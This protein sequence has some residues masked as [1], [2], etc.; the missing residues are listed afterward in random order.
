[1]VGPQDN[2][3]A[4]E[5]FAHAAK[6]E[7]LALRLGVGRALDGWLS[8]YA[9]GIAKREGAAAPSSV[10]Y[11][12]GTTEYM[13]SIGGWALT[14]ECG[15]HDDPAAPEVAYRAIVNT[16]AHLGLTEAPP[17]MEAG[18]VEGLRLCEVVDK[19]HAADAFVKDWKSFDPVR[20]GDPIGKRHD[21]TPVLAPFDGRVI[22]PYRAAE[23]GQEWFY[24][25]KPNPRLSR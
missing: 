21:G 22:F 6:E 8:C 3:G 24:L 2:T 16:L 5:P 11:G 19:A 14:L 10:A 23:A 1:M 15:Q 20:A 17:P 12:V 13:R 25:A 4:I 18:Q 9:G 7:A